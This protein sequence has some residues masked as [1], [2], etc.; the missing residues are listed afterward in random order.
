MGILM[1]TGIDE[2]KSCAEIVG[3]SLGLEVDA[4]TGRRAALEA[5]RRREYLAVV[6]DET[7]AE[8][9]PAAAEAIWDHAGLAIPLQINFAVCGAARL[10]REIRAG[11]RRRKREQ[12]LSWRA[13]VEAMETE[14]KSTV[15]GL[16]LNSQ[17]ALSGGGVPAAAA[18]KMRKVAELAGNLQ[19]QLSATRD[20]RGLA[21]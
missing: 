2:A 8:C 19:R 13:A 3:A 17:L 18:E 21:A 7:L 6:M 5:L 14:M 9:D 10:V 4:A 16:L 12:T 1:V 20:T 11:L 15:A